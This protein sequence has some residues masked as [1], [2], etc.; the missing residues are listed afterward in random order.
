MALVRFDPFAELAAWQRELSR[1]DVPSFAPEADIHRT[2]DAFVVHMDL[3]GVSPNDLEVTA[4]DGRLTIS[5]SRQVTVKA[6]EQTQWLRRERRFGRFSRTFTLP[7][8]MD[9]DMITATFDKGVL[10]VRIP[11]G[12]QRKP[13]QVPVTL[14]DPRPDEAIS[15][16]SE[17]IDVDA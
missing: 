15:E 1:S 14:A 13:R 17:S 10:E 16:Q 7:D 8:G 2:E 4:D 3:P 11:I 12:P 6:D 5:A 9:T